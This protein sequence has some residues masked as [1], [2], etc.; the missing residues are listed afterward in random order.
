MPGITA[1][2]LIGGYFVLQSAMAGDGRTQSVQGMQFQAPEGFA[3]QRADSR[4][5]LWKYQ[6]EERRIAYL[7]LDTESPDANSRDQQSLENVYENCDWLTESEYYTNPQG[8][9][10]VRGFTN[11]SG[12]PER[13]YYI[14]TPGG[15]MV[16]HMNENEQF[17]DLEDCEAAI[18]QPADSVRPAR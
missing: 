14:D 15:L 3:L 9:R 7:V 16:L 1:A 17:Y 2:V 6:G 10:M 18:R 11:I 13:R 5:V 8:I 12:A 4:S